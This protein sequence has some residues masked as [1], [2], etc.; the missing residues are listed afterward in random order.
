MVVAG[1]VRADHAPVREQQDAERALAL[2]D[3]G[4]A[5]VDAAVL[6]DPRVPSV[7]GER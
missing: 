7:G 3:L 4:A 5:V 1:V 6:A 2:L